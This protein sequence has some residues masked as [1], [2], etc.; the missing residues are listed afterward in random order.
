MCELQNGCCFPPPSKSHT[1]NSLV[2]TLTGNIQAMKFGEI[3]FRIGKLTH[4]KAVTE[5]DKNLGEACSPCISQI[6]NCW[7]PRLA[8]KVLAT[9]YNQEEKEQEVRDWLAPPCF[10]KHDV[11]Q[12][13]ETQ[14]TKEVSKLKASG[15]GRASNRLLRDKCAKVGSLFKKQD[16]ARLLVLVIRTQTPEIKLRQ[17]VSRESPSLA[18]RALWLP[19]F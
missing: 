10:W 4:Y 1:R 2:A 3:W 18:D 11:L 13:S 7:D 8:Y 12:C 9:G 17:C 15:M 19:H 16:S 14:A 5:R 6:F